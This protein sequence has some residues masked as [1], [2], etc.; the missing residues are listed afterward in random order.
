MHSD[1]EDGNE[2]ERPLEPSSSQDHVPSPAGSR[3]SSL[4]T[5]ENVKKLE[6][7]YEEAA[8]S[9]PQCSVQDYIQQIYFSKL[10]EFQSSDIRTQTVPEKTGPDPSAVLTHQYEKERRDSWKTGLASIPETAGT[11][12]WTELETKDQ[13]GSASHGSGTR[14]MSLFADTTSSY[15]NVR[16]QTDKGRVLLSVDVQTQTEWSGTESSSS[17]ESETEK[18]REQHAKGA[19][20]KLKGKETKHQAEAAK[21][22][23]EQLKKYAQM[24]DKSKEGKS[25]AVAAEKRR[26]QLERYA[27]EEDISEEAKSQVTEKQREQPEDAEVEDEFKEAESLVG[28]KEQLEKDAQAKD[29]FKE[30]KRRDKKGQ[31]IRISKK[32]KKEQPSQSYKDAEKSKAICEFCHRVKRPLRKGKKVKADLQENLFCCCKPQDMSQ[33]EQLEPHSE[34]GLA[35]DKQL[36][37]QAQS[38][39]S[40]L[41]TNQKRSRVL[42]KSESADHEDDSSSASIEI[43]NGI[44][45][46][47]KSPT[48]KLKKPKRAAKKA[49]KSI[50][51]KGT[52][53]AAKKKT[54][55]TA[56]DIMTDD[57]SKRARKIS[58]TEDLSEE[59]D[60]QSHFPFANLKKFKR[61]LM[62]LQE[63]HVLQDVHELEISE[64][65][66]SSGT[67]QESNHQLNSRFLKQK[68]SL[69]RLQSAYQEVKL[70]TARDHDSSSSSGEGIE[71]SNKEDPSL[72]SD[73]RKRSRPHKRKTLK[74]NVAMLKA[75]F[76]KS[77]TNVKFSAGNKIS[78]M[79][80]KAME[81][82]SSLPVEDEEPDELFISTAVE[83]TRYLQSHK[84]VVCR[85]YP[86]G[87]RFFILFPDGTGQIYYPSG[88][89]AIMI[90]L[91]SPNHITYIILEDKDKKPQ[92]Q[93]VFQSDAYAT[94]NHENQLLW[95]NLTPTG[96][97]SF[98]ENG[99]TL[100]RWSWWDLSFH[101][102]APPFQPINMKLNANIRIRFI[103]QNEIYLMFSE[104][105][106]IIGF[107]VGAK[108][109]L[110][111]QKN[112]Q[113]PKAQIR[114]I[115]QHLQLQTISICSL[116]QQIRS[117][118]K[119]PRRSLV[120]TL[121]PQH[122]ITQFQEA[123]RKDK[124]RNN[125]VIFQPAQLSK[126]DSRKKRV[127]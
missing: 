71:D 100:K 117:I 123:K 118:L 55:S 61:S 119:H 124:Q 53:Q 93:A 42:E 62:K 97:K 90:I 35:E 54:E 46:Q 57:V 34:D 127:K 29:K 41:E 70:D 32:D 24:E 92:V 9:V 37:K 49:Q 120:E 81:G 105:E 102:H 74:G 116:L 80:S 103:R 56:K 60:K 67:V 115:E 33:P 21:K 85:F 66:S 50:I 31:Q 4:L 83:Q 108:V 101:V 44:D 68:R 78:F 40:E 3:T 107:N 126:P 82:W 88:N 84:K 11:E 87:M 10:E 1:R 111:D 17:S 77:L 2:S 45:K 95:V 112:L 75:A 94:C 39:I 106:N 89:I 125:I 96:G 58:A 52:D 110:R 72:V 5:E 26:E 69:K 98:D 20:A 23:R 109:T 91:A 48:P 79:L 25:R 14:V 73:E 19:K 59:T 18:Q 76:E 6:Q 121:E 15:E 43:A 36:H 122:L 13:D 38:S 12:F 47:A 51:Q 8:G 28:G 99:R 7:E 104:K 30:A 16:S 65:F 64:S 86:S 27:Q 113:G 22:Q 114:K 63:N